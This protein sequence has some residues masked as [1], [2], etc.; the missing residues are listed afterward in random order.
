MLRLL[1]SVRQ[2]VYTS[3]WWT[4]RW[5]NSAISLIGTACGLN[6]EGTL[7]LLRKLRKVMVQHVRELWAVVMD[8][9]HAADNVAR[10]ASLKEEWLKL[11]RVLANMRNRR[12]KLMPGWITLQQ[13]PIHTIKSQLVQWRK[14]RRMQVA[15]G[16][17][18]GITCYF[19]HA[20]HTRA[21]RSAT[22]PDDGSAAAATAATSPAAT[23]ARQTATAATAS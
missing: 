18:R 23:A 12:G 11:S 13:K 22:T 20:P 2:M 10:R 9:R 5:P 6:T 8:R 16:G 21:A 7:K 19:S 15:T 17:Q 1:H 4:L 3:R 14:L